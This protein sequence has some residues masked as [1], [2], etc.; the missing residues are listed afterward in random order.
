MLKD[1]VSLVLAQQNA[2]AELRGLVNK[3]ELNGWCAAGRLSIAPH[4]A[5]VGKKHES[6]KVRTSSHFVCLLGDVIRLLAPLAA[7]QLHQSRL[8]DSDMEPEE[9]LESACCSLADVATSLL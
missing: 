7:K 5:P 1:F 2:V 9:L 3:F 6:L 4:P 8:F